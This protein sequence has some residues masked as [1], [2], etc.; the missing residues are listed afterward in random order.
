MTD[1]ALAL[2]DADLDRAT[3]ASTMVEHMDRTVYV[4]VIIHTKLAL[5]VLR[6]LQ[7]RIVTDND[8]TQG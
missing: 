3:G 1:T 7:G 6:F 5:H 4:P 8:L 2:D